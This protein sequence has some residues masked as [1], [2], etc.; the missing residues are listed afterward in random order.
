MVRSWRSKSLS[1]QPNELVVLIDDHAAVASLEGGTEYQQV[2]L[3]P[4]DFRSFSN[5]KLEDFK[6]AKR[7]KLSPAEHLKPGRQQSGKPRVVGKHWRGA[8]PR[9]RNLR[10]IDAE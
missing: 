4:N 5:D 2:V 6:S 10:W 1:E 3:S 9:F 7:L 8:P